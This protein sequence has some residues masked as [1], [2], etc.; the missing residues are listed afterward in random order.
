MACSLLVLFCIVGGV[1]IGPDL[2]KLELYNRLDG[3]I[4]EIVVP[5]K[6]DIIF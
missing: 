6:N 5:L 2:Y 4:H 3:T 1:Q